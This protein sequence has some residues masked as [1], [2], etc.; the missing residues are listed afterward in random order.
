M[1]VYCNENKTVYCVY[2]LDARSKI[3]FVPPYYSFPKGEMSGCSFI[4]LTFS[5]NVYCGVATGMLYNCIYWCRFIFRCLFS[6]VRVPISRVRGF[7]SFFHTVVYLP[8]VR[9]VFVFVRLS[10]CVQAVGAGL[11]LYGCACM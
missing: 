8:Q 7:I 3:G 2:L 10:R 1:F 5:L 6:P 11:L 9:A 4:S